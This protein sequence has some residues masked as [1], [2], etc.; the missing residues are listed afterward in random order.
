MQG[1]RSSRPTPLAVGLIRLASLLAV[2]GALVFGWM[3]Y[4]SQKPPSERYA[5]IGVRRANLYPSLVASGRVESAKRTLIRCELENVAVGVRGQRLVAGGAST[6]LRVIPDGTI[7]RR[8]EVLAVL[9]SSDYEELVRV[10]RMTVERAKAD[11]LQAQLDHEIAKLAVLEFREGTMLETIEDFQGRITLARSD[12][13]RTTDRMNW[14]R[15]MKQKGYV[16]I[17]TVRSDEFARA[18]AEETLKQEESAFE[19]FRKYTAPKT[20][21]ELEGAVLGTEVTLSYQQLRCQRHIARLTMLEK[22]VEACTIRAPHDGFVIH[23]NDTRRQ[24]YIEEG[25]P[26]HQKQP[27]FYL[28]DLEE[29]EIVA[30]L[31][32]SIVSEV[33][34]GMHATVELETFPDR[35]LAGLVQTVSPLPTL[36]WRTDVRYFDAIVKIAKSTPG[37]RPG[38]TAQVEIAMPSR[39]NV[40]AVPTE[41]VASD[42]GQDVCFVVHEDGLERRQVKLGQVTREM[43]EVTD[44]LREGEQIVL[45]P[46][47]E[48]ADLDAPADPA[49]VASAGESANPASGAG[50]VAALH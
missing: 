43:T 18:R 44:G 23:A 25:M 13:E 29:M 7:V 36:E 27:L 1:R 10:Q 4:H 24:V 49:G 33:R 22:Q 32:E 6:L 12:L 3:R 8:G 2:V 26:V 48:E 39:Q 42:D 9:D 30:Q 45:N 50:D 40:L 21:R 5:T 34:P 19:L 46:K 35:E 17:S 11:Q 14:S 31:H 37:L 41:A 38:M 15:S 47:Q 28:P 20:L 16:S